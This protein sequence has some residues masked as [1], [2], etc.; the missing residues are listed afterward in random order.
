MKINFQCEEC[1]RNIS[2][3]SVHAGKQ[4]RCPKCSSV[5]RIPMSPAES[6]NNQNAINDDHKSNFHEDT[7][8]VATA[9]KKHSGLLRTK[10]QTAVSKGVMPVPTFVK[11]VNDSDDWRQA[12]TLDWLVEQPAGAE[13]RYCEN[14][15][16]RVYGTPEQLRK[17]FRCP[18]CRTVTQFVDYLQIDPPPISDIPVQPW[19]K[20]DL[21]LYVV[22]I[23]ALLV[24]AGSVI[25]LFVA[26]VLAVLLSFIFA[27]VGSALFIVTYQHRTS[28]S[29]YPEHL[30]S[31]EHVLADRTDALRRTSRS[32]EALQRQ[33]IEVR[34][35]LLKETE[36]EC[37]KLEAEAVDHLGYAEHQAKTVER[38][39]E[40][41]LDEQRK[42]WTQKL[43]GDNYAVQKGKIEKAIQFV[44]KEAYQ[45]PD[46]MKKEIFSKLQHDYEM[47]VRKEQEQERQRQLRD[48][49]RVEQ[50]AE[51]EAK[52]A[53]K[54]A[55]EE[56]QA[57]EAA[58]AVALEKAGAEHSA[59]VEELKQQLLEAEER[60]KRAIAQAQLTKV[61]HVYV[62]SNI[63]S[64]GEQV[65]KVG[66]TR[67]LEP[68]DRVK[69]LGDASVPFLFDVHMMIFS[70]DAPTLEHQLHKALHD[71]R[72]NRVNFRKEFFRVDLETIH[73]LVLE[74]HGEVEYTADTEAI[75]Y[76]RGL[77][78]SEDDFTYL[79]QVAER[80]GLDF[81]P[82]EN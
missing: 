48:Q 15:G 72:V 34:D 68:L 38:V 31:V 17:Q 77:E 29:K 51:K 78:L 46:W 3:A 70:E 20:Y 58:L 9:E 45:I 55:D 64:F 76:R 75:E 80:Q 10:L 12:D 44:D 82:D 81:D 16:S 1:G 47:R 50:R 49:I 56:R 66:L 43:R 67:R 35:H 71:Y 8:V 74:L 26:P 61:G 28:A 54:R 11:P 19:G 21:L 6:S 30:R 13:L 25:A 14:C 40:R 42:W 57:I 39:A 32:Y 27:A 52:E 60:G 4:A 7:W 73:R 79:E 36:I 37:R 18:E 62:I 69:E 63:G 41:Y 65:F 5:N 24:A 23:I 53:Q 2:V 22:S 33:L 59:E